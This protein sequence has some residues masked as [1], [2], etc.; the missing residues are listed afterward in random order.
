[1][2]TTKTEALHPLS[3][4]LEALHAQVEALTQEV[5]DA[6]LLVREFNGHASHEGRCFKIDEHG[7]GPCLCGLSS[8]RNHPL[9][10]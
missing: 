3:A 10:K 1:M 7:R 5:Q 2:N 8:L 4:R 6:R 9:I